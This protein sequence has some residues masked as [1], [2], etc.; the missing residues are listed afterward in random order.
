MLRKTSLLWR[1]SPCSVRS[2]HRGRSLV[3]AS[4][5]LLSLGTNACLK[6]P[7]RNS[8]NPQ[9]QSGPATAPKDAD[10]LL[11]RYV[12]A[13]GGEEALRKLK[14]RTTESEIV[15]LRQEGCEKERQDCLAEDIQGQLVMYNS[16]DQKMYQRTVVRNRVEE[17]G[18]D[19]EESW[20]V[21]G[22]PALLLLEPESARAAA[23]EDANLH[24]YLDYAK[25]GVKPRL[26]KARKVK[27]E[28]GER[29]LDGLVWESKNKDE[30]LGGREMWFDR[31]SGLLVEEI[32]RGQ[33]AGADG[34]P[35]ESSQLL[36]FQNYQPVDGI[37]IPHL[38]RQ[39]SSSAAAA[40]AVVE[41]RVLQV[42]HAPVEAKRFERPQL[43]EPSPQP[44]PMLVAYES[45]KATAQAQKKELTAQM[46]LA[47]KSFV[48][49]RFEE[50]KAAA[51][52]ALAIDGKDPEAYYILGQIAGLEGDSRQLTSKMAKSKKYGAAEQPISYLLAWAAVEDRDYKSAAKYFEAAQLPPIAERYAGLGKSK[53]SGKCSTDFLL[54]PSP[55]PT[56]L[57]PAEDG[58]LR[59]MIDTS[60]SEMVL[61]QSAA[62]KMLVMPEGQAPVTAGGPLAPYG[63]MESL[64]LGGIK[65][66]NVS[67]TIL[68]DDAVAAMAG[69]D[70]KT[71]AILG[72]RALLD[73]ALHL[74]PQKQT[75]TMVAQ[76][77][78]CK[79]DLKA[80]S[81]GIEVPVVVHEGR[82]V[83]V[84]GAMSGHEGMYL[85]N[86][87][88]RG[89]VVVGNN[90][91]FAIA[92]IAPKVVRMGEMPVVT[93]P[94]FSLKGKTPYAINGV[95]AAYGLLQDQW[96]GAGFRLDGMMGSWVFGAR[97]WTL[98]MKARKIWIGDKPAAPSPA[99]K[100]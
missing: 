80:I 33:I 44:D 7:G 39:R 94:E 35:V 96:T 76:R 14:V 25:R 88:L 74:N 51:D 53:L 64:N 21:Q 20:S 98:D 81:K 71:K 31:Q 4:M 68:P 65:L 37:Q 15:F 17:R 50:A 93:L 70:P 3:G 45:A 27:D 58:P 60:A 28:Q 42:T 36:E 6:I 11:A 83:F 12:K 84:H 9:S 56:I 99:K 26:L 22:E 87:G 92:G 73:L 72:G 47:R 91:A 2:S 41:I 61:A 34:Q 78:S 89:P 48:A 90:R 24:W 19:G 66:S 30:D 32:E 18:F 54:Q 29:W 69:G 86:T 23:R 67:V 49:A 77:S 85:L 75:L 1:S 97:P 55:L 43:G 79:K 8:E 95:P 57:L 63:K 13:L 16:A 59:V 40:E 38:L 52:A 82:F 10:E 100:K 5:L 46:D 62:Q